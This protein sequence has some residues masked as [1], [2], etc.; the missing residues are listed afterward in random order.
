MPDPL[1]LWA[2]INGHWFVWLLI[3]GAIPLAALGGSGLKAGA[4]D[5]RR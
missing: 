2:E 3:D 5:G 4:S 1:I